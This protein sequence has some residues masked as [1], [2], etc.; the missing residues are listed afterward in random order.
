MKTMLE[1]A[2]AGILPTDE[3]ALALADYTDTRALADAASQ[4]RD[5][6]FN[7][8]VT[9]SRKVF[10]PLTHLCRD[11]CHYCTF[12]QVPRKVQ[13]P[14]LSIDE[15][16][17]LARHG[18]RMGC[19]E[20]LF[21]LGEK[22]E[23]R[24]KAARDAL[25]EMGYAS[26]TDYLFAAAKAVFEETGLL[27]HLNPGNL[28]AE[29]LSRLR[30][31]SPSMGIM[32]ESASERLCEKGMPHYGSPDKIPAVRLQTLAEAG[33]AQVPFT[34]GILIGIGETRLERIE[35]LLAIRRVHQQY[36]HI[37]EI[38]VQNFRAKAETKMVNAPEPD[39]GELL[40]TI[41]CARILF[42]AQMSV[43]APP[44]LSPGVLPQIVH[45]GINDWGGVSPVTPDF[46]NPEAPWP[47]LDEL[48]RETAAAGKF[49][50]ERLTVY[51]AYAVDL[52]QWTHTD[53]HE[54]I[55]EMIDS[56][57]FP[58]IDEWC[59][60]DP[61]IAPPSA[62]MNAII[63]PPR[64]VSQDIHQSIQQATTGAARSEPQILRLFSARG[65]DFSSAVQGADPPRRKPTG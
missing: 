62:I 22:P 64:H 49:L 27:P 21:T 51:P 33:K 16:L 25:A 14:Y 11:V 18:Q 48:T 65:D 39:L 23:L 24:Y 28:D 2:V 7:N 12:A 35:S 1:N 3:E 8:V 57:G 44:N 56:E 38:I 52:E 13:A 61:D 32:L 6:G 45:A 53:L 47:H 10:I 15:V 5:Q 36:G 20:A 17:E 50:T 31:V 4:M 59:P 34:T 9:Y 43:Q 55:L 58:R 19:K 63:N 42:G 46:V 26:T 60:G 37:Q 40:W 54:R 30:S 41:A 29:E